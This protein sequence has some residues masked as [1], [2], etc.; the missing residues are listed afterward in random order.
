MMAVNGPR[1]QPK[2][3]MDAKWAVNEIATCQKHLYG[4]EME[5]REHPSPPKVDPETQHKS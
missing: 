1:N 2:G 4:E 5:S 3:N